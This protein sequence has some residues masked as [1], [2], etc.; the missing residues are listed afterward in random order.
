MFI[1]EHHSIRIIAAIAMSALLLTAFQCGK[2]YIDPVANP[3]NAH[4]SECLHHTDTAA[5][6]FENPDSVS[7]VYTDGIVHIT[8]HNLMV[9]CATA[10]MD[11]GIS[12]TCTR[13]G[14]TIHLYEL[15]DGSDPQANCLC[16]VDNEFDIQGL[17]HGTYTFVFHAWIP[18]S[19]SLTFTF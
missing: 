3:Y 15:E 14:S 12:V 1:K 8:H 19:K 6:G 10:M 9:N 18:E 11:G 4:H 2:D 7:V 13:E 5:K 16:D 17:E